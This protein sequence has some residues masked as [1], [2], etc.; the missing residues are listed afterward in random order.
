MYLRELLLTSTIALASVAPTAAAVIDFTTPD[1]A[2]TMECEGAAGPRSAPLERYEELGVRVRSNELFGN[3]FLCDPAR[4][5]GQFG[6]WQPLMLQDGQTSFGP[7]VYW[8]NDSAGLDVTSLSGQ[9]IRG[10]DLTIVEKGRVDW[11]SE[12]VQSAQGSI[13]LCDGFDG[14]VAFA[15]HGFP[16]GLTS[17]HLDFGQTGRPYF[18]DPFVLLNAIDVPEPAGLALV[19]V[20]LAVV[21]RR[22]RA[23]H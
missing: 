8:W 9:P 3:R 18:Q 7:L 6:E 2:A 11:C 14:Y 5:F 12:I 23:R 17:F 1:I 19:G 15:D 13:T 16:N 21:R 10:I 4:A 22:R 20:A